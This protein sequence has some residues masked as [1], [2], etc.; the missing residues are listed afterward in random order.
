MA[1]AG[2][3]GFA[4]R[5]LTLSDMDRAATIHRAAFDARLPWLAGSHTPDQDRAFYRNRVFATCDLWGALDGE[6]VGFIAFREN[7]VDQLYVLP[8]WQGRR[9]GRA[10]LRIAKARF[11]SLQLYAFQRNEAARRFYERQGFVAIRQGDGSDNEEREPDVL[12]R[13]DRE[14]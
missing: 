3:C 8:H 14:A 5:R 9:V 10:L 7:W 1:E 11:A 6:V 2:A 13:W 12:Y 4:L